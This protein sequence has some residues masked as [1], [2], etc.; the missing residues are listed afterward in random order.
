MPADRATPVDA[1]PEPDL[2]DVPMTPMME[3]LNWVGLAARDIK[4]AL[5]FMD[6]LILDASEGV[7]AEGQLMGHL[8]R[9]Q[10]RKNSDRTAFA[11]R[12]TKRGIDTGEGWRNRTS[13]PVA[14]QEVPAYLQTPELHRIAELAEDLADAIALVGEQRKDEYP[15]YHERVQRVTRA[16]RLS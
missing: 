5:A 9:A 14:V 3:T 15:A 1:T 16:R 6:E 11:A 12:L 10:G 2:T 4:S 7:W 13:A 8:L